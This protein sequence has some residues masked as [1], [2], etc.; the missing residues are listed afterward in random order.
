M[1][2]NQYTIVTL[3]KTNCV[4]N[5]TY[6]LSKM[7][8]GICISSL[9]H[10]VLGLGLIIRGTVVR[11][12]LGLL[13]NIFFFLFIYK[14]HVHYVCNGVRLSRQSNKV[15]Y[16]IVVPYNNNNNKRHLY[17]AAT[18]SIYSAAHYNTNIIHTCVTLTN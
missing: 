16:L 4:H 6:F 18:I 3:P 5:Y 1:L 9:L 11:L 13:L 12:P 15:K 14:V 2:G 7:N 8:T 10:D 17:C